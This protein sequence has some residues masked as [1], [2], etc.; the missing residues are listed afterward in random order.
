MSVVNAQTGATVA[1]SEQFYA[2]PNA[3]GSTSANVS[4]AVSRE[5]SF[6]VES[7]GDYVVSFNDVTTWG[8]YH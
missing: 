2:E 3:N 7:K 5:L 6:T 8:G 4:S 1:A